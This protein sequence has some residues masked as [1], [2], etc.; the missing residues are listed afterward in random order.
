MNDQATLHA[1]GIVP[2]ASKLG[3]DDAVDIVVARAYAHPV[4]PGR[5]IVRL[6]AEGVAAGDDLEMSTLGFAAGED[7][8]A[9]GKERKRPLGFPGW[10]LVNDP[11]NARFAL[12]VVKELKKHARKAKSKPGHAKDAFD[13]IAAKLAKT[14]PHFLPSFYEEVGRVFIEHGAVSFAATMFGKARQIETV[15]ALEVDEQHRID[16]FLEF[17]LAGAVTTKALSDY[18]KQL[19]EQ[20]EPKVAYAHFR[21]LCVQRTLGGMPPWAGMAKDLGRLSKAA[22]LDAAKEDASLVSEIIESPALAKAAG[23]FWRSYAGPIAELGKQSPAARGVLLNLFPTGSAYSAE[24]DDIWLD[25]LDSTGAVDALIG[26][27]APAEAQPTTGRAA[28]FDKLCAHV[29]RSWRS[30]T[31]GPRAFAMLRRMAPQL[32]ADGKPI[33]A[34]GRHRVDLDLAELA[35][36][37]GVPV[38]APADWHADAAQWAK[39]VGLPEHGRDPVRVAAHPTLG[40]VLRSAVVA[41][42]GGVEFDNASRGKAGFLAAKRAWLESAIGGAETAALPALDDALATIERKVTAGTFAELPDLHARFAAIDVAPALRRTLAIGIIDEYGWP[43]LEEVERELGGPGGKVELT[44]HGGPP[45]IV[46]ASKTRG[47]AIVG[48]ER[49][50]V[51]DFVIPPKHELH[52]VRF[53]QGDFLVVL[54]LGYKAVCYWATAPHDLWTVEN[55]NLWSL[56]TSVSYAA[57]LPDGAWLESSSPIRRG[58]RKVALGGTATAYDGTTAWTNEYINGEYK[59]RELTPSGELGRTSWPS[60]IEEFSEGEWKIDPMSRYFPAPAGVTSSPLGVD[61]GFTGTRIR[62]RGKHHYRPEFREVESIDGARLACA[63][64]IRIL[65]LLAFPEAGERRP[66]TLESISGKGV[67]LV[68]YDPAC[69]V[70]G[71]KIGAGDMGYARGQVGPMAIGYL[72]LMTPRDLAGSRRIRAIT[73]DDARAL[74]AAAPSTEQPEPD[75]LPGVLPEV[76]HPR[77][78]K[79]LTGLATMAAQ[80]RVRRDKLAADR[81]PGNARAETSVGPD[82]DTLI[83]MLG[84]LTRQQWAF[85][86][87]AWAQIERVATLLADPDRSDRTIKGVGTSVLDWLELAVLPSSLAFLAVAIGTPNREAAAR[88]YGHLRRLPSPETLRVVH[89]HGELEGESTL[90][91]SEFQVRWRGGNAYVIRQW[92]YSGSNY[93]VLEY[94]PSGVFASLGL[95][96][97]SELRGAAGGSTPED[98]LAAATSDRMSWSLEAAARL[99]AQT[100]MTPSEAAF[101][102][103]G[104]PCANERGANF[105]DKDLRER[106][107]LKATQAALAR[108]ALVTARY[109]TKIAAID[110]AGRAGVAALLDGTAVDVLAA[111]WTARFGQRVAIPEELIAEADALSLSANVSGNLAM[112][113]GGSDSPELTVDGAFGFDNLGALIRVG[114]A[115]PLVGQT[116]LADPPPAFDTATLATLAVYLP[117]LYAALP[118]GDPLLARVPAAHALGLQRL[119][120]P[121]LW[122]TGATAWLEKDKTDAIDRLLG[123]LGGE[124]LPVEEGRSL[125][126][127]PG[128]AVQRAG[129][130]VNV[131]L[132]VAAFDAKARSLLAPILAQTERSS[133][134]ERELAY[135]RSDDLRAM[136]ARIGDTPV[137]A[138]G[139][140]Q[141]PA[142]SVPKLVGKAAKHLEVSKDAAALYLQYLVLLWPTAKAIQEYNGWTPAKLKELQA[143]LVE[144]ELLVEAKRERAQRG[145][146]LP[147]AWDA[148][149]SPHPPLEAWKVSLYADR[150]PTGTVVPRLSNQLQALAPFHLLFERA[151]KR[152]EDGDKPSFEEVTRGKR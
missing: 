43:M 18:A 49:K 9:V 2:T 150:S 131:Y 94:A 115:E 82:D 14:V 95:A 8:G 47:V 147:G 96:V 125:R 93:H 105:L 41:N 40:L 98:V 145:H 60:W 1:G 120:N 112:I 19:S 78:R 119:T 59:W 144:H 13:A 7:R 68:I 148:L 56:S 57:V 51:H 108:D 33:K 136:M 143:E 113:L 69:K 37:L 80:Q 27:G 122:M 114:K 118:V 11:K 135:I 139:W 146:F 67:A 58:D 109:E 17:A 83:K 126:R 39:D 52:T 141:N 72:H 4:L 65:D 42:I 85:P 12:D 142:L 86:G 70:V 91:S 99:A 54:K 16:G 26:D 106:L 102:W 140:E 101:A 103:A 75:D 111:A 124:L 48:N 151:W 73:D 134:V 92:G 129:S 34:S 132:Q 50:A 117:F 74:I 21:Q 77:L 5:K 116:K 97:D 29:S 23:E 84:G 3:K 123:G 152:I 133:D 104:F 45:A 38:E 10:A 15:H 110:A 88:L 71:S 89:A 121:T 128:G 55:V 137:P 76:T 36:E 25:L 149:K 28:W 66:V 46:F 20:C 90:T 87:S 100:G 79:G 31:I 30:Q 64:E 138:G 127:L 44:I 62:W 61:G 22:K 63:G 81:A 53:I 107:G 32:V 130:N 6:C 24:L 35:L